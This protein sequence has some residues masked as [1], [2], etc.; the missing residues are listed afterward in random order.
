MYQ[1]TIGYSETQDAFRQVFIQDQEARLTM[2]FTDNF[3]KTQNMNLRAIV[4][5]IIKKWWETSNMETQRI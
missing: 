1:F 5:V 2:T 4:P 3:D